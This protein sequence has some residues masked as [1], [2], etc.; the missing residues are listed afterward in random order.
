M[1][2]GITS[3]THIPVRAHSLPNILI[4]EF[5]RVDLIL[6]AGDILTMDVLMELEKLA[7]VKA[8]Y[9]NMDKPETREQLEEKIIVEVE[10]VKIGLIHGIGSKIGLASRIKKEFPETIDC[11]VYGHTHVPECRLEDNILF[12]NPGSPTDTVFAPYRSFGIIEVNGKRIKGRLI[13]ID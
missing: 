6:H 10:D 7:P 8:V 12:F 1:Q 4:Q 13:K 5:S 9:G 2:I 11:I 3:D